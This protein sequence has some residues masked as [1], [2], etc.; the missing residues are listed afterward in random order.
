MIRRPPRSTLFPYT[1]L[2]RSNI[3]RD[4]SILVD[5]TVYVFEKNCKNETE[6]DIIKI[7]GFSLEDKEKPEIIIEGIKDGTVVD[8]KEI[9]ITVNVDDNV[10]N[11]IIPIVK[12]NG[13]K[14]SIKDGKYNLDLQGGTNVI[15]I[16][17]TDKSGNIETQK[18][19]VV[20]NENIVP[21]KIIIEGAKERLHPKDKIT[22]KSKVLD[23]QNNEIG[24]AHV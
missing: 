24:R 8:K 21:N 13:K 23:E 19:T 20:Y 2:F 11:N 10:D 18:Y 14:V 9:P 4:M 3:S 1:T 22:L 5:N 17:A 16:T 6:G 12:C 15:E 7:T